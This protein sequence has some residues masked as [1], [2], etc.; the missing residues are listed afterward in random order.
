MRG[1]QHPH[2]SRQ[3]L[4]YVVFVILVT[5]AETT[6]AQPRYKAWARF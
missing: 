6:L 2:R 1:A 4:A 5:E 3:G